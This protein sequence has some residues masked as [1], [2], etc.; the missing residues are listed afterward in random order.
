M[1][2][3]VAAHVEDSIMA[4][5]SGTQAAS[6]DQN[7][8][9]AE[10]SIVAQPKAVPHDRYEIG[11]PI[12]RGGMGA[13]HFAHDHV[14]Q[15][16]IAIKLLHESL[17]HHDE[18]RKRFDYEAMITSQLQHPNIPPIHDLG[19]LPDGRPFLA[20]KLIRGNTLDQSLKQRTDPS[21]DRS[22][23]LLIFESICQAVGYAHNQGIIHRDLKPLNVMVGAFGEVQVMDWGLAKQLRHAPASADRSPNAV[24]TS[25][26]DTQQWDNTHTQAGSIMGTPAYMA[27]E[28]A[29]GEIDLIGERSDVFGLGGILCVILTGKA[30]FVAGDA[31]TTH[32]L[33]AEANVADAYARL[34]QSDAEPELIALAKRCLAPDRAE[35]FATGTE[36]AESLIELRTN[37]EARAKLRELAAARRRAWQFSGLAFVLVIVGGLWWF[38]RQRTSQLLER[39]QTRQQ[40]EQ[41]AAQRANEIR[42]DAEVALARIEQ[43]LR[44]ENWRTAQQFTNNLVTTD[45][46]PDYITR[47]E[48]T[49]ADTETLRLLE[50]ASQNRSWLLGS[51]GVAIQLNSFTA[52]FRRYGTPLVPSTIAESTIAPRLI[53]GLDEWLELN[54]KPDQRASILT[55]LQTVD[56]SPYRHAIRVALAERQGAELVS[57]LQSPEAETLPERL[58]VAVGRSNI[59]SMPEAIRLLRAAVARYPSSYPLLLAT[60]DRIDSRSTREKRDEQTTIEG[61]GYA[62]AALALLPHTPAPAFRL[63]SLFSQLR[64]YQRATRYYQIAVQNDSTSPSTWLFLGSRLTQ[65]G[66]FLSAREMY[67]RA[68]EISKTAKLDPRYRKFAVFGMMSTSTLL[69]DVPRSL[70]YA[71]ELLDEF[72]DDV[73]ALGNAAL[74]Y[75]TAGELEKVQKILERLPPNDQLKQTTAQMLS[76]MQDVRKRVEEGATITKPSEQLDAANYLVFNRK[77]AKAIQFYRL[78]FEKPPPTCDYNV[79]YRAAESAVLAWIG[80]G[81]DPP[82][83]PSERAQMRAESLRWC[84]TFVATIGTEMEGDPLRSDQDKVNITLKAALNST[85][86]ASVRH[87]LAIG[88]MPPAERDAWRKVWADVRTLIAKTERP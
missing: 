62:Q 1:C 76:R 54:I 34:D 24:T 84:Q 67:G 43:A 22:Q 23:F 68:Y 79:Y 37:A 32:R 50:R 65:N 72:P 3:T 44:E 12:A 57:L 10:I 7:R 40:Q 60:A 41:V 27:P 63:G 36:V 83:S 71:K 28:Q 77:Y 73:S 33:A 39:E 21:V 53:G 82:A 59:V 6:A 86:I 51:D 61:V 74:T 49:R 58:L 20:M 14:L 87:P 17:A 42:R 31:N 4:D 35:R 88:L 55:T 38:D 81:V 64:S 30:P 46:P 18:T 69:R 13:V 5:S 9:S 15:R 19:A 8:R 2:V 66:D 78:V 29:R 48:R 85:F 70:V 25:P 56:P 47:F 75:L 26:S 11:E 45:W 52:A 80:E 16:E